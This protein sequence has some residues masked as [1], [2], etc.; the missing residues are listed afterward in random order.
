MI[1]LVFSLFESSHVGRLLLSYL[2]IG[3]LDDVYGFRGVDFYYSGRQLLRLMSQVF[4]TVA[5][6]GDD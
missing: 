1:R 2:G 6:P 5:N 3:I 4:S